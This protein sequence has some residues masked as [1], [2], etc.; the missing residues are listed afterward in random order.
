M[1]LQKKVC[2]LRESQS[3]FYEVSSEWSLRQSPS[4]PSKPILRSWENKSVPKLCPVYVK[5]ESCIRCKGTVNLDIP[6]KKGVKA[7]RTRVTLLA[8][9]LQ[10]HCSCGSFCAWAKTT[11]S[12][13]RDGLWL[14]RGYG[15]CRIGAIEMKV[16][17]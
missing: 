17:E 12:P 15:V 10:A 1:N 11:S 9:I 7:P 2:C 4:S 14:W 16:P 8:T 6:A 13:L 3:R 5:S